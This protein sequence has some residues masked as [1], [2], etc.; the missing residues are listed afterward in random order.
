MGQNIKAFRLIKNR[1]SFL[2]GV[3]SLIDI[4]KSIKD[5]YNTDKTEKEADVNSLKSDWE[6]VGQD[7]YNAIERYGESVAR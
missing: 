4:N 3:I 1:A 5:S 6:A 7:M 2:G